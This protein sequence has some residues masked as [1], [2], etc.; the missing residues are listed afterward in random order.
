MSIF[1]ADTSVYDIL[2]HGDGCVVD[3]WNAFPGSNKTFRLASLSVIRG[4]LSSRPVNFTQRNIP[5][6]G[7]CHVARPGDAKMKKDNSMLMP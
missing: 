7:S 4:K 2:A 6:V 1:S 3:T 5:P